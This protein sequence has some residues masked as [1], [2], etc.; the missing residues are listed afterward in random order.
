M[1]SEA[2]VSANRRN[3]GKSTGPRTTQ[4]KAAVAQNAIKHGLLA[5]R[6]LITGEDPQEFDL[7]R[8]E[9]LGELTPV[10]RMETV[11]AERVV[12]LTWR[13]QR[14]ERLQN[15]VF[16]YLLAR[17]LEDSMEDFYEELSPEDEARLT[18]DPETDPNLAVGRAIMRDYSNEKVLDRLGMYERRIEG[19]LYRTMKELQN[20]RL[21]RKP[22]PANA[23][24]NDETPAQQAPMADCA[25]QSQSPAAEGGP[26]PADQAE[27]RSCRT[28]PMDGTDSQPGNAPSGAEEGPSC[29]TKPIA[30]GTDDGER[31][32]DGTAEAQ[33]RRTAELA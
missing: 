26:S 9:I 32:A 23:R 13:I 8:Q 27:D 5:R 11:L 1:A 16:E 31:P 6:N 29:K 19:S 12:S 2:Q 4:G 22:G 18:S 20:R 30:T 10:G 28:K 7:L 21:L 3:A 17:D 15:E 25:K 33:E 14:A 24:T